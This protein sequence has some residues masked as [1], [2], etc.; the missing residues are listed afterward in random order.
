MRPFSPTR[1]LFGLAL[2][3]A[4]AAARADDQPAGSAARPE[5]RKDA[6]AARRH[7]ALR[8]RA[9]K[10]GVDVLFL[11]D[12]ITQGWEGNG[13][14]VWRKRFEPL[15]AANFGIGGD[16]T[17][18]VLWRL[19]GGRELEGLRPRVVVLMIGT[20]NMRVNS[21]EEIAGGVTAVV[22]ELNKQLPEAKVLLLGIFPRGAEA[23]DMFRDKIK[24][25]NKR[26]AKLEG[27]RV[28]FLD[29]GDKFLDKEGNLP[30]EVM[31]DA[32]HLSAKGY[33]IW[34]DAIEPALTE[35]LKK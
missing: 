20:N 5:Q 11:G 32:L 28:R 24:E 13:K 4:A 14:E 10:G 25:V 29:V 1:C 35:M 34:A 19:T 22:R 16:R 15:R 26:L 18:H 9:R 17:E 8:E 7:E 23:H 30:K 21:A 33:A 3:A 27:R 12:S 31:P 6:V 2:L